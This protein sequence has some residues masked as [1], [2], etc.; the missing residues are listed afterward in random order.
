M[1]IFRDYPFHLNPQVAV[2][3]YWRSTVIVTFS[4]NYLY[5]PQQ[6]KEIARQYDERGGTS[7]YE[8]EFRYEE[9]SYRPWEYD[10]EY[11]DTYDDNETGNIDEFS[12]EKVKRYVY[13]KD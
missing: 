6:L 4:L 11:D 1:F 2:G 7:I 12:A 13:Q 10:D 5:H 9:E 8:D 3:C